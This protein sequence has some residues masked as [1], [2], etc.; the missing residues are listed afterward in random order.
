MSRRAPTGYERDRTV[1]R[2]RRECLVAVTR[3]R[4]CALF[5]IVDAFRRISIRF[6]RYLQIMR[7]PSSVACFFENVNP[8]IPRTYLL[9]RFSNTNCTVYYCYSQRTER[10]GSSAT[11]ARRSITFESF[12]TSK[13]ISVGRTIAVDRKRPQS[14]T[15]RAS[16]SVYFHVL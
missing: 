7:P 15:D 12:S 4:N 13:K 8:P 2:A 6:D 10:G 11:R 5:W 3:T 14:D 1:D 16:S 9:L